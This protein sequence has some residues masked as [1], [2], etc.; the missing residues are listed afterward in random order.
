[1]NQA[2]ERN[3][4]I[5]KFIESYIN[6][7]GYAPNLREI[8]AGCDIPLS[9]VQY[10]IDQLEGL[11]CIAREPHLSRSIRL[12]KSPQPLDDDT[13]TVY[14]YLAQ[15]LDQNHTPTQI[16]IAEAC[17]LSRWTVRRCLAK[18]EA[19]GIIRRLEGQRRIALLEAS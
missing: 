14:D 8:E 10:H 9:S 2:K 18:L 7:K 5:Y 1:M 6:K 16:D 3:D 15:Q 4:A 17:Y 12:V 13:E 11:G 19:R